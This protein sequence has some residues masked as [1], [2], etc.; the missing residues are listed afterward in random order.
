MDGLF[1]CLYLGAL[2]GLKGQQG[3]KYVNCHS[4]NS[5]KSIRFR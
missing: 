4:Y 2:L 3:Q 1:C 5:E